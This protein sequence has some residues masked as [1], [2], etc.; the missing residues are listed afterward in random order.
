MSHHQLAALYLAQ[1][2]DRCV[3]SQSQVTLPP[4][5]GIDS[6]GTPTVST[7]PQPQKNLMTPRGHPSFNLASLEFQVKNIKLGDVDLPESYPFFSD[8]ARSWIRLR[9]GE[10]VDFRSLFRSSEKT[11]D[12]GNGQSQKQDP[13]SIVLPSEDELQEMA[14]VYFSSESHKVFPLFSRDI[15]FGT[16]GQVYLT[17]GARICVASGR[18]I[19][20]SMLSFFSRVEQRHPSLLDSNPSIFSQA[21]LDLLPD[22]FMEGLSLGAFGAISLLVMLALALYCNVRVMC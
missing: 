17:L 1:F 7:Q 5:S 19:I 11:H 9:T 18:S 3:N 12:V 13:Y 21:A 14:I 20:L 22:I 10:D 8:E 6:T 4:D 16:I 15:V 2:I